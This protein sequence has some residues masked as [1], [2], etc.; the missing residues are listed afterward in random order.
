MKVRSKK[1]VWFLFK[2]LELI[3][4]GTCCL[5]HWNCY[6]NHGIPHVFLLC[7]AY[8]GSIIM[9]ILSLIGSFY[10]EKPKMKHEAAHAGILGSFH[11]ITVFGH[12]HMATWKEF[13][14][15]DW[16]NFFNCSRDNA[17]VALYAASIY[18]L[19]LTFALD[20]MFS[21]Q[22]KV[23]RHPDRSKRPLSLYFISP[24]VEAYVSRFWWYKHLTSKMI[25]SAQPSEQSVRNRYMSSDSESDEEPQQ[26]TI[27]REQDD[28]PR[29]SAMFR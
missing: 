8:G 12:M 20:L 4:S 23:K 25:S 26:T 27:P 5:V 16:V 3:I 19:H 1:P 28:D 18:F 6:H 15:S 29:T 10:G 2:V 21:H 24:G 14:T 13:H 9:G 7:G 11:V 17:M 22:L